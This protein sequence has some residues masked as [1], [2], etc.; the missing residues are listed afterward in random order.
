[1]HQEGELNILDLCHPSDLKAYGLIPEFI[2]RVPVTVALNPLSLSSLV[3]ILTEPRNSLVKQYELLFYSSGIIL[4]FT[5]PA[6]R[7]IAQEALNMGTGAR[8]LKSVMEGVLEDPMFWGPGSSTKFVLVDEDAARKKC[9]PQIFSKG[10]WATF[11]SRIA[12]E[13]EEWERKMGKGKE[14]AEEPQVG[15]YKEYRKA[16]ESGS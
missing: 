5:V 7:A 6:L 11:H 15:S 1:M 12:E 13:D 16:H 14:P 3:R 10:Q 4:R 2:G 9:L 8:A